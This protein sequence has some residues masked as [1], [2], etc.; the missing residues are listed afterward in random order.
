MLGFTM[1]R[2][3]D[4]VNIQPPHEVTVPEFEMTRTEITVVQYRKCVEAGDCEPAVDD[5]PNPNTNFDCSYEAGD[6][7]N[8]PVNGSTPPPTPAR[9]GLCDMLGNVWEWVADYYHENYE[10]APT[11]GS[12]WLQP[13]TNDRLIRGASYASNR[14]FVNVY[15]RNLA[16]IDSLIADGGFRCAR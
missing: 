1:G 5:D 8:H 16:S 2:N 12:A 14:D 13:P 4:G 3:Y 9:Q 6:R 7:E 10:G 15:Y 11:D